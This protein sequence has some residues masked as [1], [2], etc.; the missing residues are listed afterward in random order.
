MEIA[1]KHLRRDISSSRRRS[2]E[3]AA[4]VVGGYRE[5]EKKKVQTT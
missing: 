4:H 5:R 2:D 1:G 3:P